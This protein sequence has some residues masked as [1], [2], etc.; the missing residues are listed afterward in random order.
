MK[1]Q[2]THTVRW[3]F[4]LSLLGIMTLAGCNRSATQGILPED[5]AVE[6][7]ITEGLGD[8]D[9]DTENHDTAMET[10]LED[11]LAAIGEGGEEQPVQDETVQVVDSEDEAEQ[12]G[13]VDETTAESLTGEETG[14]EEG[15]DIANT[16]P[17]AL[18]ASTEVMV[19]API[20]G[21]TAATYIVQ[22]GDWVYK[23]A[24][25][26]NIAPLDL[27]A[28]N[29]VIGADQ[30]V[31]PGQE[32]VIPGD[33][34]EPAGMEQGSVEG[35]NIISPANAVSANTYKVQAGDTAFS[36]ALNN[37]ITVD[38]LA[39]NND[40]AAPSYMIYVGQILVIPSQ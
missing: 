24:R 9:T 1:T 30:Q 33:V 7:T 37:G 35:A 17:D 28:A 6:D 38:T 16:E 14:V 10:V 5:V 23:I 27:L 19:E 21:N 13:T 26:F 25:T 4:I 39:D 8:A 11:D 36:I 20:I 32:L 18:E 12:L 3:F 40:I 2:Y 29:P 15:T 22:K 34:L 31:Y